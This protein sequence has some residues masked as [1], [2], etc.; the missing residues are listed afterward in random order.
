[1]NFLKSL[2]LQLQRSSEFIR[3][4]SMSPSGQVIW[5]TRSCSKG[6]FCTPHV[7][8]LI[9]IH[10]VWIH[11]NPDQDLQ[12]SQ[13]GERAPGVHATAL[14]SPIST[15]NTKQQASS[16]WVRPVRVRYETTRVSEFR[17]ATLVRKNIRTK[18]GGVAG[19]SWYLDETYIKVRRVWRS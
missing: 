4:F 16:D 7:Q 13:T 11:F 6:I 15:K 8:F 1:M 3:S 14:P 9:S 5:A 12:D 19:Q 10:P 2:G 18:R 17:F